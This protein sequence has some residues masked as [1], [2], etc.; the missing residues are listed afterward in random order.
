MSVGASRGSGRGVG[1]SGRRARPVHRR[2]RAR[3]PGRGGDRHAADHVG[4]G[5]SRDLEAVRLRDREGAPGV[6]AVTGSPIVVGEPRQ[7]ARPTRPGHGRVRVPAPAAGVRVLASRPDRAGRARPNGRG[8]R[9]TRGRACR[10]R[11]RRPQ[12]CRRAAHRTLPGA[13]VEVGARPKSAVRSPSPCTTRRSPTSR[14]SACCSPIP[15]CTRR[16]SC[17]WRSDHDD[18]EASDAGRTGA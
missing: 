13:A 9:G 10:E 14:S 15:T 2:V 17:G 3:D 5:Q 16:R 8:A 4:H 1:G 18:A 7:A 12:P 6:T 11:R